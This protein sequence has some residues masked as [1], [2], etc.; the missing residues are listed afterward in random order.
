MSD[1]DENW[2]ITGSSDPATP[3]IQPNQY[4][5][6]AFQQPVVQQP[7]TVP[8]QPAPAFQQP[9]VQT[10]AA[11]VQPAPSYQQPQG[12]PV[13][14]APIQ[15]QVP[16]QQPMAQP[17]QQTPYQQAPVQPQYQQPVYQPVTQP[18]IQQPMA[19]PYQ[20]QQYYAGRA[21]PMGYG[22]QA[23][24]MLDP[25]FAKQRE[26]SLLE[27]NK[28]LNHFSPKVDM[29]QQYE[30][31][32]RDINKFSR[33]SVAPL[34]WGIITIVFALV[35]LANAI[36]WVKFADNKI[37]YYII[38]GVSFLIGAGL[39]VMF[40]LKKKSHNAKIEKLIADAGKLSDELTLLYNGY[41]S[42]LVA[43]EYTDPRILYKLQ[44]IITAGRSATI[45]DALNTLLM[46]QRN[47]QKIE[48]AK[49][50]AASVTSER[51]EGKPAFFNAYKYFNLM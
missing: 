43:A 1:F 36:F 47:F 12:M 16:A 27:M 34:V 45:P 29:Y 5:A 11:P 2:Q 35:M 7:Q 38:A 49:A 9:V 6:P 31:L 41:G 3:D 24:P 46:F 19:Q 8:A 14:Q 33:T 32:N 15:Q 37:P 50:Q 42:C 23:Q 48:S 28:M 40:V 22:Y 51:Y 4:Q 26:E 25:A 39:I 44:Q 13:Q 18:Q 20:Q 10:Q 30:N 17:Y 21:Q